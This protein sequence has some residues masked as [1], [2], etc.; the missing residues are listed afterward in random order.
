MDILNRLEVKLDALLKCWSVQQ[1]DTERTLFDVVDELI[2]QQDSLLPVNTAA[3]TIEERCKE[4]RLLADYTSSL[5]LIIV[6]LFE[7]GKKP[8]LDDNGYFIDEAGRVY[9]IKDSDTGNILE[10]A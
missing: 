10:D 3:V 1:G 7:Q 5:N 9:N 6:R 2:K 4:S 8:V